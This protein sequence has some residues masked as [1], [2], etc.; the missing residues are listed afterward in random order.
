MQA[1]LLDGR[2][3]LVTGGA[4]GIGA[5]IARH[6]RAAGAQVF[7]TGRASPEL[8]AMGSE[9]STEPLACDLGDRANTDRLL[10][11]LAARAQRFDIVVHN[12]GIAESAPLANTTDDI[13]DRTMAINVTAPFRI[14][15]ALIPAM[16]KAGWGR[17]IHVA[18]NAGLI[19]YAYTSAYCASKHAMIGLTRALAVEVARQGITVNAVCP[20]WVDTA[21]AARAVDNIAKTSGRSPE[22]AQA[23][24]AQMSPQKRLIEPAEVAALV[25]MLCGHEARGIHGQSLVVDGGQVMK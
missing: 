19:G 22:A 25:T 18:S 12:A 1:T 14:N 8:S 23:T 15:R 4:R 9:L 3:A 20:G 24:L 17:V 7:V 6:L 11:S 21:M 2:V 10:A 16:A 13:W 5:A